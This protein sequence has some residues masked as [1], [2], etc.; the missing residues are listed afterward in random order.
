MI[1]ERETELVTRERAEESARESER[2]NDNESQ[3]WKYVYSVF[4]AFPSVEGH[5]SV[6]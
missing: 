5:K 4:R 1:V 2:T 6:A 3:I